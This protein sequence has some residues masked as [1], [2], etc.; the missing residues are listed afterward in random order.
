MKPN[1]HVYFHILEIFVLPFL[2]ILEPKLRNNL[3]WQ[4][5]NCSFL[6]LVRQ[7]LDDQF[8]EKRESEI[9]IEKR[10]NGNCVMKTFIWV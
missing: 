4:Q 9:A 2:N 7:F 8:A 3:F 5:Y 1:Q 10:K 6:V